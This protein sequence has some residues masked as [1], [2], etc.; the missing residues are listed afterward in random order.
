MSTD[1]N[2]IGLRSYNPLDYCHAEPESLTREEREFMAAVIHA[3][4]T[5]QDSVT[6]TANGHGISI[7]TTESVSMNTRTNA[8][9]DVSAGISVSHGEGTGVSIGISYNRGG[10][11]V[12]HGEG[13]GVSVSHGYARTGALPRGNC[14]GALP[15]G[16]V[17]Q[18][19]GHLHYNDAEDDC[20]ITGG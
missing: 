10:I 5:G 8:P 4:I 2:G 3:R 17:S 12:C 6:Y 19:P 11:S 1:C 15:C 16:N 7:G 18:G 13:T 20:R 14:T 9:V